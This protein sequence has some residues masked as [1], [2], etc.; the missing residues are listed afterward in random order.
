[1]ADGFERYNLSVG[2]DCDELD[3]HNYYA[4]D[5]LAHNVALQRC[6]PDAIRILRGKS[7]I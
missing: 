5:S 1:M 6:L 4:N 3:C 2:D 7:L